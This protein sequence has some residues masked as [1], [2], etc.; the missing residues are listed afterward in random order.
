MHRGRRGAPWG[1]Y[2]NVT[3]IGI[4]KM[5]L[6]MASH[7]QRAGYT[8]TVFD[9]V[10]GACE[11]ASARGMA[12]ANSVQ[13]AVDH[14]AVVVSSL[15]DD[16]AFASVSQAVAAAK[17]GTLYI[18]TSTVS[19]HA[20]ATAARHLEKAGIAYLRVPVSGNAKM[21]ESAQLTAMASGPASAWDA[22]LPLLKTWG[23]AQFY[24]GTGEQARLMKLVINLMVAVTGGMLA[25]ALTL[26]Q[27][28][29]LDWR[30]MWSVI[31][32]SAVGSPVLKA[33]ANQLIEHDYTPTFTVDQ[34]C[35]DVHL[36]LGAGADLRVPLMLTAHTGQLL[37][38][39]AALGAEN[40]DFSAMIK[41]VQTS[42]G[43]P[44]AGQGSAV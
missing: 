6:P 21:A 43:L 27:K 7:L 23:P 30:D 8:L 37:Q 5:G 11:T 31:G 10:P 26:G 3:M 42:A 22:A 16:V 36:I 19:L 40:E 14:A 35:K 12:V 18:D 1:T 17:L 38:A 4:G 25:E 9:P 20:S 2:M 13:D 44:S 33:K 24:L 34:M 15:P 28:G 41:A 29:G 32:A 39:A